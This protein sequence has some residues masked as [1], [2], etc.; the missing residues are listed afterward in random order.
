MKHTALAALLSMASVLVAWSQPSN[1]AP[2][3]ASPQPKK[4]FVV[5]IQGDIEPALVYVVRRAVK[6]ASEAKADALVLH[7]NT[8]GGR[9]D[10]TEEILQ[11]IQKFEPQA[12]TYTL[13]DTKAFSAGAFISA[14]TR[15]IY[16]TPGSVIG[17]ATPILATGQEMPK[18]I[19]EKMTSGVRGLVRAAA[20]RHGHNTAVFDAMVDR[21]QGLT[22]EGK[23]IVPK[24]K[25]LTLTAQEAQQSL[26]KPPTPLLS[27][28]TVDSLEAML[29]SAGLSAA[30]VIHVEETGF[31]AISRWIV[32]MS[33][34]LLLIGIVGIYVE[35]KT[36]GFG[37]A[38]IS[39]VAA[40][41]VFFFGHS[42]AG[43]SGQEG[44]VLFA[45]GLA[46]V[47]VEVFF[48]PG[49]LI[50]GLL[51]TALILV[52]FLIT[53][54]DRY[55]AEPIMPTLPQLRLP[56]LK[57]ASSLVGSVIVIGLLARYLPEAPFLRKMTL[58]NA[59][60]D[61]GVIPSQP[62]EP[63]GLATTDL[64]P[65]G[66]ARFGDSLLDVSTAGE[67]LC[68]GTPL[69]VTRRELGTIFVERVG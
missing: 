40:L 1:P 31:E 66:K 50:P 2:L 12:Q 18:A 7:M 69:R 43:L 26:G 62:A 25:I 14:G 28:G 19:E 51:G 24:G 9:V 22:I 54:T 15:A 42:V 6:E 27:A 61:S 56:M 59:S 44:L 68:S 65:S 10:S 30:A 4:V 55:P 57:L 41:L 8:N 20:E 53:M 5:P 3:P 48:L 13:I 39:G 35:M 16:M 46:L 36:P 33:P 58:T 60:G 64:R 47:L 45:L 34:I 52:A 21:D 23:E 63:T 38:G 37:L 11:I 32:K 67:Y 49:T 29:A 17:A